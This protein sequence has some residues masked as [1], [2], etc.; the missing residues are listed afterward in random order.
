MPLCGRKALLTLVKKD[1]FFVRFEWLFLRPGL[2]AERRRA[3]GLSRRPA[4]PAKRLGLDSREHGAMLTAGL[5]MRS[6]VP[7]SLND[8]KTAKCQNP[9]LPLLTFTVSAGTMD[10]VRLHTLQEA[11]GRSP[12]TPRI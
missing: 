2:L 9:I 4:G 12:A 11:P 3:Q 5:G 8:G 10:W 1:S 6:Q 7:V